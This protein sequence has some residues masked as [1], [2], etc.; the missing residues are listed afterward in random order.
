MFPT[1][2]M[3]ASSIPL[4]SSEKDIPPVRTSWETAVPLRF[5]KDQPLPPSS[6]SEEEVAEDE[7]E[8]ENIRATRS[9]TSK[10][11]LLSP[12]SNIATNHINTVANSS[13]SPPSSS[14]SSSSHAIG[15]NNNNNNNSTLNNSTLNNSLNA[16]MSI[17][18]R[19]PRPR[20]DSQYSVLSSTS[21]LPGGGGNATL[22]SVAKRTHGQDKRGYHQG[23]DRG[24]GRETESWCRHG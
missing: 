24:G 19:P 14:S 15:N 7:V 16:S 10:S 9:L 11:P 13:S 23:K 5:K 12:S 1:G 4:D 6:S 17:S 21:T 22:M 20:V 3:D 2:M 18:G 8:G